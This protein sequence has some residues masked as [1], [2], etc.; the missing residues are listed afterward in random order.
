[1][2]RAKLSLT[3]RQLTD[4]EKMSGQGLNILQIA[5]I[6]GMSKATFDRRM[7]DTA[8]AI[9]SLEKGRSQAAK[10]ITATAY[11]LAQSGKCPAM[12]MFWL[13]CRERWTERQLIEHTGKDGGPIELAALTDE[14]L[15]ARIAAMLGKGG[16]A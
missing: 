2:A 13:K 1:M 10:K 3:I 14:Q 8:G 4:I 9:E 11:K 12:T 16:K 7:R 15:E 5:A 6:L